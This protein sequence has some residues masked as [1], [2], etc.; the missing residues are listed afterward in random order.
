M[1]SRGRTPILQ[2]VRF[3]RTKNMTLNEGE[4]EYVSLYI[5][6]RTVTH[7]FSVRPIEIDRHKDLR[8]QFIELCKN[9]NIYILYNIY[10]QMRTFYNQ[11]GTSI[12]EPKFENSWRL[13]PFRE[14]YERNCDKDFFDEVLADRLSKRNALVEISIG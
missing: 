12:E 2:G 8:P 4:M 3:L 13:K 10:N 11:A 6:E 9:E 1:T 5:F 14:Y 7:M